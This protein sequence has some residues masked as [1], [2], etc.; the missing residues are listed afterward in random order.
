MVP[1]HEVLRYFLTYLSSRDW[2][3]TLSMERDV[4]VD[5][6]FIKGALLYIKKVTYAP[7]PPVL[8]VPRPRRKLQ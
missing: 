4:G 3:S 2:V 6:E 8:P 7:P 5:Q 1:L